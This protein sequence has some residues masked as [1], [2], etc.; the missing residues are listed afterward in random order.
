[1]IRRLTRLLLLVLLI[2]GCGQKIMDA[3]KPNQP[4]A[5]YLTLY[6][7]STLATTTSRQV[8]HWWGD[9]PDGRV[10]GFIYTWNIVAS[11]PTSFHDG[12]SLKDWQMTTTYSDTFAL[13]FI[14]LDTVYTFRI[15]AVD[16]QGLVD[17]TPAC[18]AFPVANSQPMIDFIAGTD[19]PE[20]TFTVASFYWKGSDLDGDDTIERYEYVLDDTMGNWRSLSAESSFVH[21]T[22]HEDLSGS[23][24]VFYVRAVDVAGVASKIIRMP[25]KA[26]AIWHVKKPIGKILIIDDYEVADPNEALYSQTLDSLGLAYSR[27]NLKLDRNRDG[28]FDL[29]PNSND[30]FVATMLLFD[31]IIW[32]TDS[33]PHFEAAQIAIPRFLK[34]QNK[35]ILFSTQFKEFFSEQGDPLEFSPV[36][37]LGKQSYDVFPGIALEPGTTKPNF[38][39]LKA[40]VWIPFTK[41]LIPKPSAQ[42]IYRLEANAFLWPGQPIVAVA[43]AE[44]SFFFFGV[45]FHQLNGNRNARKLLAIILQN[46]FGLP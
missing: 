3:P 7:D 12:E 17:P 11:V 45:P 35:K 28:R 30:M 20:T 18:Q 1:M 46:E 9:D 33:S 42:V 15:S 23:N 32:Y 6:P 14:D 13:K 37:S 34:A 5:T 31:C 19:I 21:L 4:P 10:V 40:N 41:E 38:P 25:R 44:N 22:I 29:M 27:W 16:D 36:D 24:H 43:N 2:A 39:W 8:L 26:N